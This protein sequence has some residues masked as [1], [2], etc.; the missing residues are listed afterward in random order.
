MQED[1]RKNHELITKIQSGLVTDEVGRNITAIRDISTSPFIAST[2]VIDVETSNLKPPT[3][4]TMTS[5]NEW[6]VLPVK[7]PSFEPLATNTTLTSAAISTNRT[8]GASACSINNYA[9][10]HS[11]R[12]CGDH[13]FPSDSDTI[14]HDTTVVDDVFAANDSAF[15]KVVSR[16]ALKRRKQT[17][18]TME[19]ILIS[20]M[21]PSP[22][23]ILNIGSYV[24]AHPSNQRKIM[25]LDPRQRP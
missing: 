5:L 25:V 12:A 9:S 11:G 7:E 24:R 1:I 4:S 16:D 15:T 13:Q 14:A 3:R 17:Q 20:T 10:Q 19:V 2:Q 23:T 8:H 22:N 18:E 21:I 6:T